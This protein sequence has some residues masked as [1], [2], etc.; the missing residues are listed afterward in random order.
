MTKKGKKRLLKLAD[1]LETVDERRFNLFSWSDPNFYEHKCGTTACAV[2]WAMTIPSFK[3]AGL[4]P[5]GYWN[6]PT[7]KRSRGWLAIQEFFGLSYTETV[8]LFYVD[9][10]S[11]ENRNPYSVAKRIR[12][13]VSEGIT[14]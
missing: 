8:E 14:L 6:V 13:L 12:E 1:L 5:E 7:Y 4:V 3:R 11:E 10:Y 9:Q 2:G